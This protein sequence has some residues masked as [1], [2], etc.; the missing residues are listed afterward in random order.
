MTNDSAIRSGYH[1][2]SGVGGAKP[3]T[4]LGISMLKPIKPPL[5]IGGATTRLAFVQA[6]SAQR[7]LA[8]SVTS[9]E[10]SINGF[11]RAGFARPA[12]FFALFWRAL[13]S[14]LGSSALFRTMERRPEVGQWR[15]VIF[16]D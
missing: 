7:I 8:K 13:K 11:G 12:V 2:V 16:A 6:S 5:T 4:Y 10:I 14:A 9:N 1:E 15:C 3:P